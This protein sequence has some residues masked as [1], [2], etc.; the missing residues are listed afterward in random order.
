MLET[1]IVGIGLGAVVTVI[2]YFGKRGLNRVDRIEAS[3]GNLRTDI[4]ILFDRGRGLPHAAER[5]SV[6]K[7]LEDSE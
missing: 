3:I 5:H 2:G 4:A 1:V 6:E 7:K